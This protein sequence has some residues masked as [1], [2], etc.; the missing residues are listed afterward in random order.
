MKGEVGLENKAKIK[1]LLKHSKEEEG[2]VLV[3]VA[4]SLVMLLTCV[5]YAVDLSIFNYQKSRLQTACDAAA[6]AAMEDLPGDIEA[7]RATALDY[8]EKNGFSASDVVVTFPTDDLYR[9]FHNTVSVASA[10]QQKTCFANILGIKCMNYDCKATAYYNSVPS[11]GAFNH[12]LFSGSQSIPLV[13]KTNYNILGNIHTNFNFEGGQNNGTV[14]GTIEAVGT[15]NVKAGVNYGS[16]IQNAPLI[17]MPDFSSVITQ[18]EPVYPSDYN[19]IYTAAQVQPDANRSTFTVP[20]GQNYT[21]FGSIDFKNGLIVRGKLVVYGD[22]TVSGK[23]PR[24]YGY[25]NTGIVMPADGLIFAKK[26]LTDP[27]LGGSIYCDWHMVLSGCLFAERNI[28]FINGYVDVTGG[29]TLSLYADTGN[30]TLNFGGTEGYGIIYAPHGKINFG[31][32][33]TT[34][35]GSLIGDSFNTIPANINMTVNNKALPYII[36]PKHAVLIE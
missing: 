18:V 16:Y 10:Q 22:I 29:K 25:D 1:E 36:G 33:N 17:D 11:G 35:H 31:N 12:L 26:Q 7:A 6:L 20:E 24:S 13:M 19:R 21:I 34:W 14:M 5:S 28:L 15:V 8:I 23:I 32:G 3:I 27:N 9:N 4:L 2:A 30:I